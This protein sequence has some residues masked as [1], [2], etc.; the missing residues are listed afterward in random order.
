[1]YAEHL[2]QRAMTFI[3]QH[4][5]AKRSESDI[6]FPY[7]AVHLRRRDYTRHNRKNIPSLESAAKQIE[8]AVNKTGLDTVFV[9]TD[10]P[11]DGRWVWM[12]R[13]V[14]R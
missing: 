12:L 8:E 5:P 1:M 4:L 10:A 11:D 7:L 3:K 9:A 2:K 6:G 14:E 13:R